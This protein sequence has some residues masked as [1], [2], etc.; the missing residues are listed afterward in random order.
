M[1]HIYLTNLANQ[2]IITINFKNILLRPT[3]SQLYILLQNELNN[4]RI[5]F[6]RLLVM[7]SGNIVKKDNTHINFGKNHTYIYL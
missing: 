1:A 5:N 7:C 6:R 2:D 4:N 3:Y